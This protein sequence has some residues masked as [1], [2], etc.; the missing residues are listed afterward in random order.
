MRFG[1]K[2]NAGT[3]SNG[4]V[5]RLALLPGTD[6]TD[7]VRGAAQALLA[8]PEVD[9]AGVW[10]DEGDIDSRSPR[11]VGI[12]HG[13]VSER[14]G[15]D[16]P[17]EWA[18]LSLEALPS[19]APLDNGR[20]VQ[21]D[22]GETSDQ[23]MLGAL[24]ELR[25]AIWAPVG[26]H[27][28]LRGVVL[29]GTCRK[30]GALPLA[31]IESI[32]A[33]LALALELEEERRLARQRRADLNVGSRL[34]TELAAS[35][36]VDSIFTR[37]IDSCTETAPGGDGLGAVFA[38]LQTRSDLGVQSARA[39]QQTLSSNPSRLRTQ[40]SPTPCWRSGDAA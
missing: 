30:H 10:I 22:L 35:G 21:Q 18:R 9:R 2:K 36:P 23:L 33:E 31:S 8:V 7:L 26:A 20:T 37:L 13:V 39:Y 5:A 40:G 34:L 32:S 11:G 27:G 29:A 24:L 19:L 15:G 3:E 28:R 38:I 17:A 1:S 16:T 4:E 25:R 6:K 14:G 12:F